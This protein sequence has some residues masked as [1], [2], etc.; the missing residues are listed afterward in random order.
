MDTSTL[1]FAVMT[2]CLVGVTFQAWRLGNEKRD[3][4]L[5]GVFSA[6]LGT[7]TAVTA[8]L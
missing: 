7:G 3:V 6:L 8:I 1:L 2:F 5:L 4:V